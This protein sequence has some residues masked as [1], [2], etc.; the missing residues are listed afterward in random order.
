[1]LVRASRATCAHVLLCALV[2]LAGCTAKPQRGPQNGGSLRVE[3][4][5]PASLD[6]IRADDP[7]EIRVVRLLFR[8]LV[9]YDVSRKT[10]EPASATEWRMSADAKTLTFTLRRDGKFS[11]GEPV[12]AD[13]YVRAFSRAAAPSEPSQLSGL[14]A[15][16]LGYQEYRAGKAESLAGVKAID[17][18]TLEIKLTEPNAEFLADLTHPVFSPIPSDAVILNQKP[19]WGEAPIG[20]GPWM[21]SGAW[22]HNERITL[23]PNPNYTG[24]DR[25]RL[26]EVVFVLLTDLDVA[27]EQWLQGNLDWTSVPMARYD[28]AQAQNRG[29]SITRPTAGLTF[30]V[31]FTNRPPTSAAVL[32]QAISLAI[33]RRVIAK[34]VFADVAVPASGI[35]PPGIPGSRQPGSNGLGACG[36]CRY[37]PEPARKMLAAA[38]LNLTAP[39]ELH[40]SDATQFEWISRIADNLHKNLGLQTKLVRTQPRSD[41]IDLLRGSGTTGLAAFEWRMSTPTPDDV[42]VPLFHSRS[43]GGFNLSGYRSQA[44]DDFIAEAR[45][46]PAVTRRLVDYQRAEDVVLRDLPIVPLWWQTEFRLVRT[47][48]FADLNMDWLGEPTFATAQQKSAQ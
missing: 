34:D 41:Y 44:F 18:Y 2:A 30:L 48:K 16:I 20:N 28:Q 6:P 11:N 46:E 25:P 21:L 27:Y 36:A 5:E 4:S 10:I 40:Y 23:T 29:R 14:L 32:R 35:V 13:N 3:S 47:D 19:S 12:K 1:M 37:D 42:L 17:D 43:L 33:E 39:F 38:H 31:L 8:G 26:A 22:R 24:P 9:S 15:P 45:S 7:E